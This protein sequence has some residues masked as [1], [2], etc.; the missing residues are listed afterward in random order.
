MIMRQSR[1]E[2]ISADEAEQDVCTIDTEENE[3][4]VIM[5]IRNKRLKVYEGE[6]DGDPD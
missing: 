5:V 2:I 6:H 4:I 1:Q 3:A